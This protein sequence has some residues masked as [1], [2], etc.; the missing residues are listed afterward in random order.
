MIAEFVGMN[1]LLNWKIILTPLFRAGNRGDYKH[2]AKCKM[3]VHV[4]AWNKGHSCFGI[5]DCSICLEV[6]QHIYVLI[7]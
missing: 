6:Q 3:C 2:C 4:N 5:S 1:T 7:N